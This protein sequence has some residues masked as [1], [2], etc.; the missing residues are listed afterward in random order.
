ML[1]VFADRGG[2]FTD[3]IAVTNNQEIIDR[4]SRHTQRFLIVPQ[5]NKKWIIVYKCYLEMFL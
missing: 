3:I 4:L 5:A 2:T 1:K